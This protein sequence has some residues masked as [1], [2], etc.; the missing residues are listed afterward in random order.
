M[1]EDAAR[2]GREA[3][4]KFQEDELPPITS[5]D[6]CAHRFELHTTIL[7]LP[8][9]GIVDAVALVDDRPTI[10]DFKTGAAGF[11]ISKIVILPSDFSW[12]LIKIVPSDV[13]QLECALLPVRT[14]PS[15]IGAEDPI[16]AM[17]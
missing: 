3:T 8:F 14:S 7:D 4:E 16:E 5:I 13:A 6:A 11:E 17:S 12:A 1:A 9:A 10:V 2:T 15:R